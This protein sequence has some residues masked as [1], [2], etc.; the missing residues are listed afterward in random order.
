VCCQPHELKPAR[1]VDGDPW[2]GGHAAGD[3]HNQGYGRLNLLLRPSLPWVDIGPSIVASDHIADAPLQYRGIRCE[4][5]TRT[6]KS[7]SGCGA[8]RHPKFPNGRDYERNV[9]ISGSEEFLAF[10]AGSHRAKQRPSSAASAVE[11]DGQ[12]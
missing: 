3:R 8:P 6:G 11:Q 1:L 10:R 7:R 2:L 4:E 9:V 5:L 12:Q